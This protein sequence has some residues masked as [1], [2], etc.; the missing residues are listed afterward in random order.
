MRDQTYRDRE[1]FLLSTGGLAAYCQ[2]CTSF[3][4]SGFAD[5][6]ERSTFTDGMPIQRRRLCTFMNGNPAD[7]CSGHSIK[8]ARHANTELESWL[9]GD[10]TDWP[11]EPTDFFKPSASV[12]DVFDMEPD[13]EGDLVLYQTV[14]NRLAPERLWVASGEKISQLPESESQEVILA[15]YDHMRF[16]ALHVETCALVL[17]TIENF[18]PHLALRL[19]CREYWQEHYGCDWWKDHNLTA[20]LNSLVKQASAQRTWTY[21]VQKRRV[22]HVDDALERMTIFEP[23]DLNCDQPNLELVGY[24]E[25]MLR[26][27]TSAKYLLEPWLTVPGLS[28]VFAE[29]GVGKTMFTSSVAL[30]VATGTD[31]LGWKSVRIRRV[32]VVDGEMPAA[33]LRERYLQ[34]G[35]AMGCLPSPENLVFLC[36]D[37]S[38]VGLPDLGT[39]EG[40]QA[41]EP[42][43]QGFDLIIVDNLSTLVR[44]G[45]ENEADSWGIVQAWA[46]RQ[47]SAGRSVLLVHHSG[48]NGAQRGTSR[49]EDVLGTVIQ[50]K[51]PAGYNAADGAKFEIHFTKARGFYGPAAEPIEAQLHREGSWSWSPV[52]QAQAELAAELFQKGDTVRDIATKLGVSTSTISKWLKESGLKPPRGRRPKAA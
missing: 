26:E 35:K 11:K 9:Q 23:E 27:F 4:T 22:W 15:G 10:D 45:A 29:R 20:I 49:R 24:D 19:A 6:L 38:P 28:M 42:Y 39:E 31:F 3:F 30:A 8:F 18:S 14:P 7:R 52:N 37:L 46:I 44:S 41:L 47:R 16:A 25:F 48:K 17:F 32:L 33:D 34:L 1:G 21:L 2:G 13:T 51:R 12:P 43:L 5:D 50:L 36:A 40:Q